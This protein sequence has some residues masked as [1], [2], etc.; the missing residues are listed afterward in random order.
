MAT[1]I[2]AIYEKG[3]LRPLTKVNFKEESILQ[4]HIGDDEATDHPHITKVIGV[5]GGRPII[6]NTRVSVQ[7]IVGYYKLG[8][9]VD[10][11]IEALPHLTQAQVFDALSYYHD[12][13]T[14]IEAE[15]R[16]NEPE[17]QLARYGLERTAD[18]RVITKTHG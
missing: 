17:I 15:M 5:C 9:T 3:V 12:H 14:D 18:G 10:D 13:Q 8:L 6:G 11:I 7:S 16:A 2:E 4:L 1:I